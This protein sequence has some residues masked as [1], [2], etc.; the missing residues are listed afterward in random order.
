MGAVDRLGRVGNDLDYLSGLCRI[1]VNHHN[2]DN[3]NRPVGRFCFFGW[4][5]YAGAPVRTQ[6]KR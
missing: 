1:G 6:E 3:S 2:S 4:G 5:G